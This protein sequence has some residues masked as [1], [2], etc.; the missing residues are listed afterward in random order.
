MFF[1]VHTHVLSADQ[2][3]F[4]IQNKYPNS[5]D[6]SQP[7]SVGM[8]PWFLSKET[9]NEELLL[10]ENQI[11]HKNCLAIGECGL[12]KAIKVDFDFQMHVFRQQIQMSEKHQKPIIIHCVR[13]FQEIIQLKKEYKPNQSWVLHGFSKGKQLAESLLK[14]G[15]LFSFGAAIINNKKL[16]ELVVEIPNTK[17]LLETDNSEVPIQELYK[18][19]AFLKRVEVDEV[20]TIIK[21]NF[22]NIFKI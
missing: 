20:Q 9:V 15:I 19:V 4:S 13:A 22:I 17:L 14:N 2:N 11:Q 1:D 8:H 12:D 7:F 18:K 10:L 6:F 3:V 5:V 16:Q 21:Q